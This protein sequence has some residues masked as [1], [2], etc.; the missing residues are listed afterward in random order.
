[1]SQYQTLSAQFDQGVCRLRIER[2]QAN[3]AINAQLV[4]DMGAVLA[5]CEGEQ[6]TPAVTVVVIEGSSTVFCSGGDFD[7]MAEAGEVADATPL[8]QLWS[9]MVAGP[10]VTVSVVRGRVNAGGIGFVAASDIVLADHSAA[11]SLS[12]LL[13]GIY[14]ACVLPFLARRAGP[15]Q[16]HY[17]TLMTRAF[18]AQEALASGLVDALGGDTELLLRQHLLRLR[19]LSRA[20]IRSYKAYRAGLSPE[21]ER[22]QP[23]AVEANRRMFSDPQVQADIRRYV[24]E[25]KFPWES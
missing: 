16:A 11:F 23:A 8:Y 19:R 4:A 14:P 7:A 6:I 2:P 18:S 15:Q 3:N 25:S 12:E 24:Q 17:M 21:L 13:F 5:L 22:L 20:G 9:R 10:F 1:M